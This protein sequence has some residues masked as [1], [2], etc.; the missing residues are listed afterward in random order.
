MVGTVPAVGQRARR[1]PGSTPTSSSRDDLR[2]VPGRGRCAGLRE[3]R[4]HAGDGGA[5]RTTARRARLVVPERRRTWWGG[6]PCSAHS[7]RVGRR[8]APSRPAP[9]TPATRRR[10]A[11][12]LTVGGR[13]VAPAPGV[14]LGRPVRRGEGTGLPR[15]LAVPLRPRWR[16]ARAG[17]LGAPGGRDRRPAAAAPNGRAGASREPRPSQPGAPVARCSSSSCSC[18][19]AWA[20]GSGPG[21]PRH[22]PAPRPRPS[23]LVAAPDAESSAWYCT[24]QSTASGVAP[25][26]LVLTNTSA[27]PVI[28]DDHGRH[29]TGA[30]RSAPP[31]PFPARGVGG[32]VHPRA[33]RRAR[34]SPRPSSVSGGGVAVTQAV[35]GSSGWSQAPCQSTTSATWYFPGGHDRALRRALRLAASTRRRRPSWSTSAS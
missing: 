19:R 21:G 8:P 20:S 10:G 31:S 14:R 22:R 15:A 34:G 27:A 16:P 5:R 12:R 4:G 35:H 13:T 11:S 24:G 9:S 28:G 32:T 30:P 1:P 23:A 26:F 3:R 18:S 25:G 33:R 29:A 2:I 6:C 17:R 7:R